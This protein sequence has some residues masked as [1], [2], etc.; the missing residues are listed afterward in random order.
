MPNT[1]ARY[2]RDDDQKPGSPPRPA[3]EPAGAH[4]S[5]RSDKTRTDPATGEPRKSPPKPA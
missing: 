1:D 5:S 3:T 4:G 2:N